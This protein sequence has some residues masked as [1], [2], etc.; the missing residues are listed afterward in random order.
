MAERSTRG[1]LLEIAGRSPG[2]VVPFVGAGPFA[3][4]S[5]GEFVMVSVREGG[6]SV[7]PRGQLDR[8][9]LNGVTL[10]QGQPLGVADRLHINGSTFRLIEG[11]EVEQQCRDA[12][13]TLANDDG[14]T[15]VASRRA[16]EA[17]LHRE[18]S[19]SFRYRRPV[20]VLSIDPDRFMRLNDAH[21]FQVGDQVL[22]QLAA[23]MSRQA[24]D[25][26]LVAR[27]RG[28]A[29]VWIIPEADRAEVHRRAE[30]LRKTVQDM[31]FQFGDV[32][33][34]MTVSIGIAMLEEDMAHG[35]EL[36]EA[37]EEQVFEAKK[38]GRNRVFPSP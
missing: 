37:A 15:E 1:A 16:M 33:V 34:E 7:M 20:W 36:I 27:N 4:E 13:F 21:G 28:S 17:H 24:L 35:G 11:P 19:R 12:L 23:L 8:P 5:D 14:L 30:V 25:E 10:T 29:F 2:R 38:A 18:V 32:L 22:R 31:T 6:W 3:V 9:L 26:E